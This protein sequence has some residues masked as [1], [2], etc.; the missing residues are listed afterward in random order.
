[1]K[2]RDNLNHALVAP[3]PKDSIPEPDPRLLEKVP[4]RLPLQHDEPAGELLDPEEELS[5]RDPVVIVRVNVIKEDL[6]LARSDREQV[7]VV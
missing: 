6:G 3:A 2:E 1:M 7:F 4:E 5:Q